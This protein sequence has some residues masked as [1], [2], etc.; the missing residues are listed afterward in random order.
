MPVTARLT[1]ITSRQ[2]AAIARASGPSQA[3]SCFN[4]AIERALGW[5][6]TST[7]I[8]VSEGE[9]RL[10]IKFGFVPAD[11]IPVVENGVDEDLQC[12]CK[13]R[14]HEGLDRKL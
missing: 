4:A 5:W 10:I 9:R 7:I 12:C 3:K 1:P 11:R 13:E 8:A 14:T 2:R 6:A